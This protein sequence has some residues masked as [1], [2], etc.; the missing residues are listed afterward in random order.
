MWLP[1]LVIALGLQ[2]TGTLGGSGDTPKFT[3][4]KEVV[5]KLRTVSEETP[6][7]VVLVTVKASEVDN[8]PIKFTISDLAYFEIG[9]ASGN[10]TMKTRWD[11]ESPG[12]KSITLTI[13]AKDGDGD[14]E[15]LSVFIELRNT[16]DNKPSFTDTQKKIK[17]Q[18]SAAVGSILWDPT[19]TDSDVKVNDIL[20]VTCVNAEI[21]PNDDTC[22]VFVI[23]LTR[24]TNEQWNGKIKLNRKLDYEV[25]RSYSIRLR[26][27]DGTNTQDQ[28]V[29]VEVLDVNDSPPSFVA[30]D[31][32]V[33]K[34]SIPVDSFV[35][36]VLAIDS[37][38]TPG[39]ARPI[40]YELVGDEQAL[41][42]FNISKVGGNIT[43]KAILDYDDLAVPRAFTLRVKAKELLQSNPEQLGNDSVTTAIT[44]LT[45]N[46]QDVN[47]NC[48]LFDKTNYVI[49]MR[50]NIAS[51]TKLDT[52]LRLTDRDITD[53]FRRFNLTL[54]DTTR[55]FVL[56]AVA[57]NI[58]PARILLT[59]VKGVNID[60]ESSNKVYNLLITARDLGNTACI[61]TATIQIDVTDV[62]DESPVFSRKSYRSSVK[63]NAGKGTAVTVIQ[64]TDKDSGD[65]GTN[66]IRYSFFDTKQ[67]LFQIDSI[68]GAVTVAECDTPG[69]KDCLDH[70]WIKSYSLSVKATDN[71]GSPSGNNEVIE[72]IIDILNV[73][74][75]AP[76]FFRNYTYYIREGFI[77]NDNEERLVVE[78]ID[79]DGDKVTYSLS[80]SRD[81]NYWSINAQSG[82]ITAK[83]PI[84]R[85]NT[86]DG[87]G[88]FTFV[89]L[90]TDGSQTTVAN[91]RII[92]IDVNDNAPVFLR[93][94]DSVTIRENHKGD[95]LVKQVTVSDEDSP[96]S[97]NGQVEV[98]IESG[99]F[100]KFVVK[101]ITKQDKYYVADIYTQADALFDYDLKS[102]YSLVLRGRDKG[103]PPTTGSGR[104][105]VYIQ[106]TNNKNPYFDPPTK[107]VSVSE[108]VPIFTSVTT[109]T[110]N[111]NDVDNKLE[112]SFG[113]SIVA[114]KPSGVKVTDPQKYA[115]LF[116]ISKDGIVRTNQKLDRDE[117]SALEI[118][119][120]VRDVSATPVQT[121]TGSLF[122][123]ILEYNDQAPQFEFPFYNLEV[124][125]ERVRGTFVASLLAF[126]EDDEISSYQL[127]SNPGNFFALDAQTG[128]L[129]VN[130]RLDYE[131]RHNVTLVV[132]ATDSGRP[133]LSNTTTVFV[134][135]ININDNPPVFSKDIYEINLPEHSTRT[136]A[137]SAV[138]ATDRD[139]G[140]FGVVRYK[141]NDTYF[142]V[143]LLTGQI[144]LKPGSKLDRESF[145][146]HTFEVTA[147]DSPKNASVQLQ[148]TSQVYVIL[149]DINDN[150][151]T[152]KAG[153]VFSGTII[154]TADVGDQVLEMLATDLDYKKNSSINFRIDE[155]S[156][157][158][159]G[160]SDLFSIL[161]IQSITD[162]TESGRIE[163]KNSL[164]GKSREYKFVVI[165]SDQDGKN[166]TGDM[167]STR[168]NVSITVQKAINTSPQWRLPPNRNFSI[169]VLESQYDGMLVY[170]CLATDEDTGKAGIVD[171]YFN[172]KGFLNSTTPE[173]RINKVT[174][175]ISATVVY[176]REQ[177]PSYVL[178]IV[179]QDQ[180][181][182]SASSET[183]LIVIVLD[184]NDNKPEFPM[185]DGRTIP[186]PISLEEGKVPADRVI[187][188]VSA[189]DRDSDH[190]NNK[191]NYR[192]VAGNDDG[193]FE[194]GR[195][196]GQLKLSPRAANGLD[197]ETKAV[198]R[199]DV[200]AY[201]DV[202]DDTVIRN[203]RRR[204]T[205]PSIV[206]VVV[207]VLDTNDSPPK[208][209]KS[210]YHG[211]VPK[212]APFG[213]S[214]VKVDAVDQD[215]NQAR[216]MTYTKIQEST[217]G[218]FTIDRTLG[219]VRNAKLLQDIDSRVP[220]LRVRVED[221][222]DKT[223]GQ[224]NMAETDVK[225]F[226]TD[227]SNEVK[228][229]ISQRSADVRYYQDQ[230][231]RA[232][233]NK[234]S[235]TP[236]SYICIREIRDHLGDD[237][238]YSYTASD[239]FLSAVYTDGG[240]YKLYDGA[241][242]RSILAG[243]LYK[244]QSL[245]VKTVEVES[246]DDGLSLTE[247]PV[248][249]IFIIA[250]LLIFLALIL[251]CLACCL[252]RNSKKKKMKKLRA[253]ERR[254]VS[255]VMM[256]QPA[257]E[258]GTNVNPVYDNKGFDDGSEYAVVQKRQPV[259]ITEPVMS[260][261][262]PPAPEVGTNVNP[263]YDNKGF[264]DGN[265]YAVVQKRRPAQEP[266][267]PPIIPVAVMIPPEDMEPEEPE[268]VII[269]EPVMSEEQPE[270]MQPPPEDFF[271]TSEVMP[272][273]P[274][275]EP[276]IETEVV[277]DDDD[278][279]HI[280]EPPR[281]T[282]EDEIDVE[283][284]DID[285]SPSPPRSQSPPSLAE[286]EYRIETNIS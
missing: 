129:T 145:S 78:A 13:T 127:V 40:R 215:V 66:G 29:Q 238:T 75:N 199:M 152:F 163:V 232:M 8:S 275:P 39:I 118:P 54:A 251:F 270:N 32:K 190:R 140:D 92:V 187:G 212:D 141:A 162:N 84:Y 11:Y 284:R 22:S 71:K 198:Y 283:F 172:Y 261:E 173:F 285:G 231:V 60:Y 227:E 241:R 147:Y 195:E 237:G 17:V 7:R 233:I 160:A 49:P 133:Q 207:T 181:N 106:D 142:S 63:E 150:C 53:D 170:D 143:N 228:L 23:E 258:V 149:D 65:F 41:K 151:P 240:K 128:V 256:Q 260:E 95:R 263:V 259:I 117:V 219:I 248:L 101:R 279:Y 276:V 109:V 12:Q 183:V 189:T 16:N 124:D 70:E 169:T 88:T 146:T 91:I 15:E 26:A 196:S 19:V 159:P 2:I 156:A 134:R 55:T 97:G 126:D 59:T 87:N 130:G 121:G 18:E 56:A 243:D 21:N 77:G 131:A 79:S 67:K 48:P 30:A 93:L 269:T 144:F 4:A 139:E 47:D 180:G 10:I 76:R 6:L 80:D 217:N 44:S 46:L 197:R 184:V 113:T 25:A 45:I 254:P 138:S 50:E 229:V 267:G 58:A 108:N 5:D 104:L 89:A 221:D 262:Q 246:E 271:F 257:P 100:G 281:P 86:R 179:A 245:H 120:I 161:S 202:N 192:I 38:E 176:D 112:I 177:V 132:R 27:F 61:N 72:L 236:I 230:I 33:I 96:T 85:N 203:R 110:A 136:D 165:A 250:I 137:L 209:V 282:P 164:R 253:E 155:R 157:Q 277:S 103:T 185:R 247:D 119:V 235:A 3:N 201:N 216:F 114:R 175:V 200:L 20:T 99:G 174:G 68:S 36:S 194:I 171:Y 135:I 264:D 52:E 42:Y 280:P 24:R 94:N 98:T 107:S 34:E 102:E 211:C 1:L 182:P 123:R 206:M 188:Q 105:I 9:E 265:E 193:L 223:S 14:S 111:D 115:N 244:Y 57:D 226:V 278:V 43:T 178:N 116:N 37:D 224:D 205:N 90:A 225:I 154:E 125:E 168:A 74:D 214:I 148:T 51:S 153:N 272:P 82:R 273:P 268:P 73:N 239:V 286:E 274:E 158:P 35:G 191:V 166:L 28:E 222:V 252:I 213:W 62:N 83:R 31:S 218:Y 266:V 208:F 210:D 249:A 81:K 220:V 122:I 69:V 186:I 204:S 242:L 255:A 64:A 234:T 167:C